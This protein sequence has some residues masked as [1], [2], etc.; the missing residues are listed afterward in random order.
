MGRRKNKS[1]G[2]LDVIFVFR[3]PTW[4]WGLPLFLLIVLWGGVATVV[5]LPK[6]ET[7][8]KFLVMAQATLSRLIREDLPRQPLIVWAGVLTLPLLILTY[9]G[10]AKITMTS[11]ALIYKTPLGDPKVL[12]WVD[13]EEVFIRRIHHS[14]EGRAGERR[15][16][17]LYGRRPRWGLKRPKIVIS[18]AQLEGYRKA[19]QTA[20]Q[21]AVPAI[22]ERLRARL[23]RDGKSVEF[24]RPSLGADF[25]AAVWLGLAAASTTLVGVTVVQGSS[26]RAAV[27][28]AVA[29]ASLVLAIRSFRRRWYALDQSSLHVIRRGLPKLKIPLLSV[30]EAYVKHGV[31]T[32]V[33]AP[34]RGGKGNEIVIRD[35]HY[36]RNRGVMLTLLRLL[37]RDEIERQRYT[38][39]Q[40]RR[41]S[42]ALEK[43]DDGDRL[44]DRP[45]DVKGD[46]PEVLA[47]HQTPSELQQGEELD[48]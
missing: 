44:P 42:S 4:H 13:V 47:S 29:V 35:R 19:E 45:D 43:P 9:R 36:F 6:L 31:M 16:L 11:D 3:K 40:S 24:A 12:R 37:I 10:F 2:N 28:G 48:P 41:L 39:E 17:T 46:N 7:K 14:L 8:S 20:V 25:A 15:I 5:Y 26:G 27:F 23:R 18:N 22:A 34:P 30:T 21:I 1:V 38:S 33:A 32:I